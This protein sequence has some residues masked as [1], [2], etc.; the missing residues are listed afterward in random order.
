MKFDPSKI[1]TSKTLIWDLADENDEPTKKEEFD[2]DTLKA[3]ADKK[4][5]EKAFDVES[6]FWD[7][8]LEKELEDDYRPPKKIINKEILLIILLVIIVLFFAYLF[9]L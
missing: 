1:D 8:N 3:E 6:I 2:F 4:K 7:E 5:K 9:T